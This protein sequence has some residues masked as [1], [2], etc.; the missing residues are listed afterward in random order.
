MINHSFNNKIRR[1]RWEEEKERKRGKR[2]IKRKRILP[3]PHSTMKVNARNK[4]DR[5]WYDDPFLLPL[6]PPR[7]GRSINHVLIF[8]K[9]GQKGGEY[10]KRGGKERERKREGGEIR[11]IE[12]PLNFISVL[13]QNTETRGAKGIVRGRNRRR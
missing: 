7:L 3:R 1:G 6:P 13:A 5:C 4:K 2:T 12:V 9:K 10:K 8:Q 11:G